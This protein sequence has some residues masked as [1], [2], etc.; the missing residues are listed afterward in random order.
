MDGHSNGAG[1]RYYYN[2]GAR[3][4]LWKNDR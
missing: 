4:E 1:A 2:K 3:T